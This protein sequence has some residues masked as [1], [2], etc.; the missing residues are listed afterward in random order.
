M[1]VLKQTHFKQCQNLELKVMKLHDNY[2]CNQCQ[3]FHPFELD[4]FLKNQILA[5]IRDYP[6][7]H[8]RLRK[9]IIM[10]KVTAQVAAEKSGI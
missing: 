4:I 2:L 3:M 10:H 1:K 6:D 5:I 8:D 7:A 9:Q